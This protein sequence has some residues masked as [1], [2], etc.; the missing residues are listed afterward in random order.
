M[1]RAL[2]LF[3]I[4][5]QMGTAQL[6]CSLNGSTTSGTGNATL[7]SL[8]HRPSP[9]GLAHKDQIMVGIQGDQTGNGGSSIR[10]G[11]TGNLFLE[12]SRS[13]RPTS[14]LFVQAGVNRTQIEERISFEQWSTD[15]TASGL[16]LGYRHWFNGMI[17]EIQYKATEHRHYSRQ[18]FPF[19]TPSTAMVAL[20]VNRSILLPVGI[21]RFTGLHQLSLALAWQQNVREV[22]DVVYD[23]SL[24][25]EL[26]GR[27]DLNRM[28]YIKPGLALD[29]RHLKTPDT[30]LDIPSGDRW[31]TTIYAKINLLFKR[32]QFRDGGVAIKIPVY[33][34]SSSGNIPPGSEPRLRISVG[35]AIR[36]P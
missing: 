13:F 36:F 7:T 31:I 16:R 4:F 19:K 30:F 34:Q 5:L 29:I 32:N 3:M 24:S 27:Y 33:T 23:E 6:C 25:A 18:G 28:V 1:I 22:R 20:A 26:G 35:T 14:V 15:I 10:Y 2:V 8:W 12:W 11:T 21:T 17:V 9:L